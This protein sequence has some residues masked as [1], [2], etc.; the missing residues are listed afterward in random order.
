MTRI[1]IF[2]KKKIYFLPFGT[3]E[4]KKRSGHHSKINITGEH[5]R[6]NR[7]R[8]RIKKVDISVTVTMGGWGREILSDPII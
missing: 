5:V 3:G 8:A 2:V 4:F 7:H 6:D 1:E